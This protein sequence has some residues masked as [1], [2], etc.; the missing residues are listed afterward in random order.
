M[1]SFKGER[2]GGKVKDR[3]VLCSTP[4]YESEAGVAYLGLWVHQACYR[5]ENESPDSHAPPATEASQ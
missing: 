5:R 1:A 3:C 2:K 4:V